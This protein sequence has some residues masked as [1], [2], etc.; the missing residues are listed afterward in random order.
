MSKINLFSLSLLFG[1]FAQ[2]TPKMLYRCQAV[3]PTKSITIDIKIYKDGSKYTATAIESSF[4]GSIDLLS[5]NPQGWG[6]PSMELV[7]VNA[8]AKVNVLT[9]SKGHF[10]LE[11]N[12]QKSRLEMRDVIS[13]SGFGGD[14]ILKKA[15]IKITPAN[16]TARDKG[17]IISTDVE[18]SAN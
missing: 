14:A 8:E 6:M 13:D 10:S 17:G 4:S 2:A 1:V 11:I 18:C 3:H 7:E 15:Q 5:A 16:L 9:L 12:T